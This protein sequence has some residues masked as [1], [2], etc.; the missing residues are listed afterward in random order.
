MSDIKRYGA[1]EGVAFYWVKENDMSGPTCVLVAIDETGNVTRTSGRREYDESAPTEA[2]AVLEH[3]GGAIRQAD[4][5]LDRRR[6][7]LNADPPKP[8]PAPMDGATAAF[9][10]DWPD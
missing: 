5:H 1:G 2:D 3:L 9:L 4:G 8:K 6:K 7:Q 10:S